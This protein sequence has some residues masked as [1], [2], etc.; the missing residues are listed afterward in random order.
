[1]LMAEP[2]SA[3]KLRNGIDEGVF[4]DGSLLEDIVAGIEM[5][6]MDDDSPDVGTSDD[7]NK[8]DDVLHHHLAGTSFWV[9]MLELN[10]TMP[11]SLDPLDMSTAQKNFVSHYYSTGR[12][13]W[14]CWWRQ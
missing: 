5:G 12:G 6:A 8:D 13:W 4:I 3:L 1:M 2:A 14:Q 7:N 10:I 11:S 9:Q